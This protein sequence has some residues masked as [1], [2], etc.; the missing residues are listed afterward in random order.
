LLLSLMEVSLISFLKLFQY[1]SNSALCNITF[2]SD[3]KTPYL[4][5][6]YHT[7]KM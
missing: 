4:F 6:G 5:C 7:L 1:S 2:Y 3:G